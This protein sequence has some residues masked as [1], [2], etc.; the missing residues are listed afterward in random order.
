MALGDAASCNPTAD[1]RHFSS[2]SPTTM[3]KLLFT[4]GLVG[5]A[6]FAIQATSE[7][8]PGAGADPVK[9]GLNYPKTG[10][11]SAM[12]IDQWRAAELA[13]E[14]INKAGGVLGQPVEIAW[15]YS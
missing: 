4:A 6:A 2:T 5:I 14:E 10:P 8:A 7:S 11:Y 13:V 1:L 15:R 3:K 9:V 12:G